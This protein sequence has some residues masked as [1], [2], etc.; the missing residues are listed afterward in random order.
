MTTKGIVLVVG[1][2]VAGVRAAPS[3]AAE[4][5]GGL[6]MRTDLGTHAVRLQ[7]GGRWRCL[8]GALV[9]DPYSSRDG[10]A[11]QDLIVSWWL[12]PARHAVFAGVRSTSF[13]VIGESVWHEKLLVGAASQLPT[14][15]TERLRIIMGVE[16]ATDVI[17]HGGRHIRTEWFAY[18]SG[19]A[20]KD[21]F[22]FSLFA[23]VE[24]PATF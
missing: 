16:L 15:W 1:F 13:A 12:S 2:A 8:E 21:L 10:Q 11:D 9:L 22:N 5:H 7:L 20:A 4:L 14:L 17:R 18:D 3:E 23:R 24:L 19:R 6:N